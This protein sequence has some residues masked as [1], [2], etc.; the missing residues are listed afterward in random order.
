MGR[1][2]RGQPRVVASSVTEDWTSLGLGGMS[3]QSQR[4]RSLGT[5]Q[6]LRE[7]RVFPPW[8]QT[9]PWE[10]WRQVLT[11]SPPLET[12]Q[13]VCVSTKLAL[14][15]K[16]LTFLQNKNR[17]LKRDLR[18]PMAQGQGARLPSPQTQGPQPPCRDVP[19]PSAAPVCGDRGGR[20]S[21]EL[22]P[23]T[24]TRSTRKRRLSHAPSTVPPKPTDVL[25]PRKGASRQ[26]TV[27]PGPRRGE[28][29]LVPRNWLSFF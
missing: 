23:V 28:G 9:S 11:S 24:W 6:R 3:C 8:P 26:R 20:A 25:L 7:P 14:T 19:R 17:M 18:A 16:Y 12:P 21:A 5:A 1:L 27:R 15:L 22:S 2:S 4:H 13:T 29:H 10:P